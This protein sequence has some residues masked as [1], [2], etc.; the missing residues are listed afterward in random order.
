M[1]YA[2]GPFYTEFSTSDPTTGAT[3]D[4]SPLPV[5][6]ATRN[7]VDDPEFVLTV[8][9]LALGRYA[10]SGTVPGSYSLGDYVSISVAAT[11]SGTDGTAILAT[12][13]VS[14]AVVSSGASSTAP[15]V[16][17]L[18]QVYCS[19]ENLAV[20]ASGDFGLLTPDWQLL[21][22][23]T[24]GVIAAGNRWLLSSTTVDFAEAGVTDQHVVRLTKP[25]S[26]F[27]GSG[28]FLAV[29][30]VGT[31]IVLRRLGAASAVGQPPA[32]A[33]GLTG[34]AFQIA[35]L[36]PQIEEESF[37]LN[38]RFSIDPNSATRSPSNL[39]DFRDLRYACVLGVLYKRY[40]AET[41][42]G[43]GDFTVKMNEIQNELSE[44][45]GRLTIRW[46]AT[47]GGDEGSQSTNW[48][49]TRLVR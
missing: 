20:R 38:R 24:D 2:G 40:A 1:P 18:A 41:R 8:T 12:F 22:A 45:Y 39:L 14:G 29:D 48:F 5:A 31:A 15:A 19:D 9:R 33:A 13:T 35:T 42:S 7:G 3:A 10:V 49:S 25:T 30:S 4:A 32:P 23:G 47:S 34:V 27:P 36:D 46:A 44:V 43:A 11:V 37:N 6:T 26:A 21:A 28:Q 16:S 17:R